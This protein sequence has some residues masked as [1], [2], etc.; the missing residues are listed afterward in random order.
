M[1][2]EF[3]TT[4]LEEALRHHSPT[5]IF[6]TDQSAQ[7]TCPD[8]A[9]ILKREGVTISM[10]CKGRTSDNIFIDRGRCK[11]RRRRAAVATTNCPSCHYW[12]ARPRAST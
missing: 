11:A 4:A 6:N 5:E 1:A 3:C 9:G 7:F 8:F 12:I 10:D 2:L